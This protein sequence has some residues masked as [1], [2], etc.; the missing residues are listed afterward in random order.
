MNVEGIQ[1]VIIKTIIL[2]IIYPYRGVGGIALEVESLR[3]AL[4]AEVPGLASQVESLRLILQVE[5]LRLVL[6]VDIRL[7]KP[8]ERQ[9]K[10]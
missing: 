10:M 1:S 7:Q 6:Q 3:R 8:L 4:Q 9:Y 2:Q 5:G